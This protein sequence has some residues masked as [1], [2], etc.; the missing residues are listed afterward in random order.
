MS[1]GRAY[2]QDHPHSYRVAL[3]HKDGIITY[4]GPYGT[5]GAA[6]G[7]VTAWKNSYGGRVGD[8]WVERTP[9]GW[10]RVEP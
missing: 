3:E 1:A 5:L 8:T 7:Q 4:R 10:E 6:R 2:L 9:P